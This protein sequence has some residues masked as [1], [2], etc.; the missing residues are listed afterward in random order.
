VKSESVA[1]ANVRP[2]IVRTNPLRLVLT[3]FVFW[4]ELAVAESAAVVQQ[5]TA[6]RSQHEREILQEFSDLLAIPNLASDT[7][8]IERNA[9]AIRALCE[10]R[11]LTTQLLTLEGA[12]PIVVADLA[13]PNAKRTIA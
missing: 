8:N 1:R 9:A 2:T 12:P 4:T 7:P 6:W 10:K 13:A 5:A 11:G 3:A